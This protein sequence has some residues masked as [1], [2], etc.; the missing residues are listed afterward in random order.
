MPS[1]EKAFAQASPRLSP[2]PP[3]LSSHGIRVAVAAHAGLAIAAA[4]FLPGILRWSSGLSFIA[5]DTALLLFVLW[6]TRPL[7][8]ASPICRPSA[9]TAPTLGVIIAAHNEVA[10]IER[11]LRALLAQDVRPDEIL[12]ADD[13]SCD[14][15]AE[16]LL[17]HFAFIPSAAGPQA[18]WSS[19]SVPSLRW[20]RLPHGGKARA[21]NQALPRM[22]SEIVITVDADT[23]LA[24][25]AL[26]EMRRAFA[27][28]PA[29]V[30]A[31][32]V[33]TPTGERTLAGRVLQCFQTYEYIRNFMA[34]YAWMRT[35]SLLLISGAFA[36]FRRPALLAVGGFDPQCLVEDYEVIHRL[37]RHAVDHRLDWQIRVIG[38]ARAMTSAPSSLGNFLSQRQRWFA[39]FLQTQYWNRDMIGNRKYGKLG[40]L[41]LPVKAIDTLQPFCS[42]AAFLILLFFLVP[43]GLPL[44]TIALTIIS[45]KVL[46][47]I[48]YLGWIIHLY[49]RWTG[50]RSGS[51]IPLAIMTALLEPFSFQLLRHTGALLGWYRFLSGRQHWGKQARHPLPGTTENYGAIK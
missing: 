14:G 17:A 30:A 32:G 36:G 46:F 5:Y 15:T 9:G 27:E 6:K 35:D 41:M 11:T 45:G 28:E 7:W 26:A 51:N 29:L 42:L 39:G 4:L 38:R 16:L 22:G 2:R 13:G 1:L 48:I 43:G 24:S 18:P 20:L 10:V 44:L 40:I 8:R 37:H 23:R 33:L 34:R 25:D 21:L 47:D 49:R 3:A 19:L 12:I 50:D 31:T